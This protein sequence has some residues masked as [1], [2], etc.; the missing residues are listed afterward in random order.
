MS[1]KNKKD[2]ISKYICAK[3][4]N[5]S[6]LLKDVFTSDAKL[7]MELKTQNISFPSTTIGLDDINEVLISKF[8][9]TY[10]N[11]YTFCI[12]D[13]IQDIRNSLT[14]N[15]L[16]GMSEKRIKHPNRVWQILLV[17]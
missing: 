17:F 14:C 15:W 4:K 5:K 16:V 10:E 1:I 13:S 12:N 7:D 11:I 3:D 8:N 9:D 6:N 2:T